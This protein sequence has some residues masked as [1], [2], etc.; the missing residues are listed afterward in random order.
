MLAGK[1][2]AEASDAWGKGPVAAWWQHAERVA[3]LEEVAS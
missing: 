1:C 3:K 2:D